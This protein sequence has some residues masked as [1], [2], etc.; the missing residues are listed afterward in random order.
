M[1]PKPKATAKLFKKNWIEA[2][3]PVFNNIFLSRRK[4]G[5]Y[6]INTR[7]M[8]IRKINNTNGNELAYGKFSSNGLYVIVIEKDK[9]IAAFNVKTL[10]LIKSFSLTLKI[11]Y[12]TQSVNVSNIDYSIIIDCV[13]YNEYLI[14]KIEYIMEPYSRYDYG[15]QLLNIGTEVYNIITGKLVTNNFNLELDKLYI[16]NNNIIC[17]INDNPTQLFKLTPQ[18]SIS[19]LSNYEFKQEMRTYIFEQNI[20]TFDII[21]GEGLSYTLNSVIS[22]L[23]DVIINPINFKF[24]SYD[25]PVID[26]IKYFPKQNFFIVI[27]RLHHSFNVLLFDKEL[28]RCLFNFKV[29]MYNKFYILDDLSI[30]FD[31]HNTVYKLDTPFNKISY[32][33]SVTQNSNNYYLP[34]ELLNRIMHFI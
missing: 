21:K 31:F 22:N 26:N 6:I 4:D 19:H 8:S 23:E 12:G 24:E 16:T 20:I 32:L 11:D 28:K 18:L 2:Q 33:K 29:N 27:L 1:F 9:D 34:D 30:L 7:N 14:C 15:P 17:S 25:E 3:N 5:F 13:L 10:E